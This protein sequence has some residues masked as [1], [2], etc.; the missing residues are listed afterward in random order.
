[1]NAQYYVQ[2]AELKRLA[3]DSRQIGIAAS[4]TVPVAMQNDP[5]EELSE[6]SDEIISWYNN[7]EMISEM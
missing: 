2:D 3:L 4:K 7:T 1:M 5:S 6:L